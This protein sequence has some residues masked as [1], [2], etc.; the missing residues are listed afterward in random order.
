MIARN[1]AAPMLRSE[2]SLTVHLTDINDN[3]PVFAEDVYV[4]NVSEATPV[5]SP[6]GTVHATDHDDGEHKL[7]QYFL[8]PSSTHFT[9]DRLTGQIFTSDV[10]DREVRERYSLQVHVI[11]SAWPDHALN[12]SASVTIHV[13]DV[14]DNVPSLH[15]TNITLYIPEN[16]AEGTEIGHIPVT[17]PD[18]GDSGRVELV[19][20]PTLQQ[21]EHRGFVVGAEGNWG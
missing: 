9:I 11:D 16:A 8:Y 20:Q 3:V 14:N 2:A 19:I 18:E 21:G 7:L 10:L 12:S 15:H 17:D 6:I 4:W 13:I 5:N 1:V